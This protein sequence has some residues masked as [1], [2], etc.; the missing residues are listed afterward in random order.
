MPRKCFIWP[1]AKSRRWS[2]AML[3]VGRRAGDA[4][5]RVLG[6]RG[7]GRRC[8]GSSWCAVRRRGTRVGGRLPRRDVGVGARLGVADSNYTSLG[9]A[10][11]LFLCLSVFVVPPPATLPCFR[12]YHRG[13]CE[14]RDSSSKGYSRSRSRSRSWGRS[15]GRSRR[16]GRSL[17]IIMVV[18]V[19]VLS[20]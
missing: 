12:R 5:R 3:G 1:L 14:L 7:R 17:A 4:A 10:S 15:W 19:V 13:S 2:E 18:L 8:A 11:V 6:R 9:L 20:S 16:R